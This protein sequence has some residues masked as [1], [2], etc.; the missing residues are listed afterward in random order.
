MQQQLSFDAVSNGACAPQASTAAAIEN[1]FGIALTGRARTIFDA[2]KSIVESP[3][4][5]L[6]H[7]RDDFFHGDRAYLSRTHGTGRYVWVVRDCGTHLIQT[8]VHE[9]NYDELD[10][11][12]HS[13]GNACDVYEIDA[14]RATIK[15]IDAVKA[16]ELGKRLEYVTRDGVVSKEC[17]AI[18]GMDITLSPWGHGQSPQGIVRFTGTDANLSKGDL[19]ALR[20]IAE[21]EV[22]ARTH[23]LFTRTQ[24]AT[25]DGVDIF[26]L[27]DQIQ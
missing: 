25:L 18:A 19:I 21:W 4:C 5:R 27:I 10:A 26:D 24:S 8:G 6:K 12:L 11:V 1:D 13:Y 3:A 23:S 7:Y 15:K 2:M 17:R 9:R 20:Q 16:R 22:I 14:A